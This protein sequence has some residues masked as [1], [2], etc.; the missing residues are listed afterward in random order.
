MSQL[1]LSVMLH[2]LSGAKQADMTKYYGKEIKNADINDERL[3]IEFEDGV[4]IKI[5]DDG[6]CCCESRYITCDDNVKDLIGGVLTNIEI[7]ESDEKEED[8]ATHEW[9]FIEIFTDKCMISFTTHSE[10]NGYYGGF[11]FKMTEVE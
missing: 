1:G 6:Q 9:T 11:I 7:K 8:Y 3:L 5:W 10:H 2:M 4:K